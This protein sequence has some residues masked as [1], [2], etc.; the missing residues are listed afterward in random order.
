MK[1]L[2]LILLFASCEKSTDTQPTVLEP[3]CKTCNTSGTVTL[4]NHTVIPYTMPQSVKYCNG[5]WVSKDGVEKSIKVE[6]NPN[7]HKND[8]TWYY[9]FT[10]CQ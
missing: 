2:L 4:P 5:E 8:T 7:T 3:V 10:S 6:K 9:S 1:K